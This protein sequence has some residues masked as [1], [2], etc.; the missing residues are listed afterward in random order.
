M[1]DNKYYLSEISISD[2]HGGGLTLQR[3]LQ[4]DI[5][6]F[7]RLIHLKKFATEKPVIEALEERQF[8]VYEGIN[9]L[10]E[11]P[12]VQ[13]NRLLRS[14][15]YRLRSWLPGQSDIAE[16]LAAHLLNNLDM[17]NAR[18]LVVPQ[19]FGGLSVRV[20]NVLHRQAAINYVTWIMDDHNVRYKDGQFTYPGDFEKA[21]GYHLAQARQVLV[22]SP[23][24]QRFYQ[25]RF[26][27]SS[28][29][30][31]GPAYA[32]GAPLIEP[33]CSGEQTA[34]VYF[35]NLWDWQLKPLEWL[36]QR[37]PGLNAT[38]DIYT[39]TDPVPDVLRCEGVRL[40]APVPQQ[41]VIST[42]RSFD[43]VILP[44]S[45]REAERH[46]SELNIATKMSECLAS[47]TVVL[48]IGPPY[49]AMVQFLKQ[50]Q[51]SV[52][53]DNLEAERQ[54]GQL[55]QIKDPHYRKK[56]LDN[57]RA[58]IANQT[59]VKVMHRQWTNAWKTKKDNEAENFSDRVSRVDR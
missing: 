37:L 40:H 8:N 26:G 3:V 42:M 43:A 4:E 16:R 15:E 25:E 1:P 9:P 10:K 24:M 58:I 18:W 34:F 51:A 38:L 6:D 48:T 17:E 36:A 21:F 22:I 57:C 14:L 45:F 5:Y 2:H 19:G 46:M 29:V 50:H 52:I 11:H 54:L 31:F 32:I 39:Q 53:I 49:A 44:V 55:Q 30:L 12:W 33:P 59:S 28:K 7:D 23:V 41:E 13:H 35:G 20:C 56:L 47:G 27:I